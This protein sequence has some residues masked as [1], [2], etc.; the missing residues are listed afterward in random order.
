MLGARVDDGALP[1]V[2]VAKSIIRY[3]CRFCSPQGVR[4]RPCAKGTNSPS[5]APGRDGGETRGRCATMEKQNKGPDPFLCHPA[6]VGP[7][8][9]QQTLLSSTKKMQ[10]G[11]DCAMTSCLSFKNYGA[12]KCPRDV[13]TKQNRM[14]LS[15]LCFWFWFL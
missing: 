14:S 11:S 7:N 5:T 12:N 2:R 8:H 10:Q 3:Q 13:M 9:C 6:L 1:L 15:F 4:I